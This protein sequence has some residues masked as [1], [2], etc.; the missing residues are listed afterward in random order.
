MT[1]E[2]ALTTERLEVPDSARKIFDLFY[3]RGWTDGAR[4]AYYFDDDEEREHKPP[5]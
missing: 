2:L 3:E 1:A 4:G 5:Y